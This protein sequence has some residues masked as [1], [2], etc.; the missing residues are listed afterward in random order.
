MYVV[1]LLRVW[2]PPV[3]IAFALVRLVALIG[4]SIPGLTAAAYTPLPFRKKTPKRG[5]LADVLLQ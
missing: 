2:F 3:Q 1:W 5:D 4:A